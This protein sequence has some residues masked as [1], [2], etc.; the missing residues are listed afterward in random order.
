[1]VLAMFDLEG[2][3]ASAIGNVG[4]TSKVP[5]SAKFIY[6]GRKIYLVSQIR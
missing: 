2:L 5:L 4:R 1:M 3:I 6:I